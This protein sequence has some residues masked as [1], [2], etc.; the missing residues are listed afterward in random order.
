LKGQVLN[1]GMVLVKFGESRITMV[2]LDD[3]FGLVLQSAL[4]RVGIFWKAFTARRSSG[5]RWL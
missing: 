5:K 1:D 3:E 2:F 4:L